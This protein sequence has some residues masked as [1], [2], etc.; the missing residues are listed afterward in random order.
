MLTPHRFGRVESFVVHGAWLWSWRRRVAIDATV[1]VG[2]R[3]W[4]VMDIHLSP[5]DH[6]D[7]R[8]SEVERLLERSRMTMPVLAGDLNDRPGGPVGDTLTSYGW[9]DAWAVAHADEVVAADETRDPGATNWTEGDRQ[10]RPPTQRLDAVF[11]PRGW[12]VSSAEVIVD[13]LPALAALSDHLPLVA[14]VA[15]SAS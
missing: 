12:T 6:G 3:P 5:H 9:C 15:R 8:Q 14:R 10:G 4:R 2:A 13:P 7:R 1:I 11:V